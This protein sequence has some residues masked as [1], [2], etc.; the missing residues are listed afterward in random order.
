MFG[1]LGMNL[2]PDLCETVDA[3]PI[4]VLDVVVGDIVQVATKHG[5]PVKT[6]CVDY[7]SVAQLRILGEA[8]GS[9]VMLVTGGDMKHV[10]PTG[11]VNKR[12]MSEYAI[13]SRFMNEDYVIVTDLHI[14]ALV[15]QQRGRFC[16]KCDEYN[17]D[18]RTEYSE[19]FYCTACRQNPWR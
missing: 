13:E 12:M 18:V 17:E 5:K 1:M 19:V 15:K 6:D 8:M 2:F 11:R 9:R 10:L 14:R 16:E 4:R 7:D 3:T